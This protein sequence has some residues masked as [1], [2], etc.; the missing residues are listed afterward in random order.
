MKINRRTMAA[1]YQRGSAYTPLVVLGVVALLSLVFLLM[2]FLSTLEDMA[3]ELGKGREGKAIDTRPNVVLISIDSLRAD[4][5]HC[6][7]YERETCPAID[8]LAAEGVLFE[9]VYSTTSWTLPAHIALMTGLHDQVHQVTTHTRSLAHDWPV[10]A[11]RFRDGGYATGGFFSGPYLHP[12]F[13]FTRGFDVYKSCIRTD[14]VFDGYLDENRTVL[15][16]EQHKLWRRKMNG[17]LG[18]RPA[19]QV[20]SSAL[21]WLEGVRISSKER[22]PFFLFLH[23]FDVHYDYVPP[24]EFDVFYPDYKGTI[25]GD[26][27]EDNSVYHAGMAPDDLKRVRSLYDGEILWTDHHI[28]KLLDGLGEKG[29]RDNTVIIVTSDHGDE[30]FEHGSKGHR[31]TNGLFAEVTRI[32]LVISYPPKLAQG[33]RLKGQYRIIDIM[34]TLINLAGLRGIKTDGLSIVPIMLAEEQ[35]AQ[36]PRGEIAVSELTFLTGKVA[37]GIDTP[38]TKDRILSFRDENYHLTYFVSS[39]RVLLFNTKED[40]GEMKDLSKENPTLAKRLL[41]ALKRHDRV[42]LDKGLPIK[43]KGI[44]D[45]DPEIL[46]QLR[47]LGY[48][49]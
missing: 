8:R 25:T 23:F 49:R 12:I 24:P 22:K 39:G 2:Y 45:L 6:Y 16:K 4:H 30:F 38:D 41:E 9:N 40:P 27:Y 5:L 35:E 11:E 19:P 42:L 47:K 13:G 33:R 14:T 28:Q 43:R 44:E 32:P 20:L 17:I 21:A 48:L 31:N 34:P 1:S 10:L 46:E 7:G 3:G 36:N 29:L 37:A 18:D 26:N 15:T